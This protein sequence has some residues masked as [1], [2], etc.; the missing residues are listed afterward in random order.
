MIDSD[1]PWTRE[2]IHHVCDVFGMPATSLECNTARDRMMFAWSMLHVT[3][4]L[5]MHNTFFTDVKESDT[6]PAMAAEAFARH[7]YDVTGEMVIP[8]LPTSGSDKLAAG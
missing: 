8:S 7:V 6:E 3:S 2:F 4:K 5:R 1:D